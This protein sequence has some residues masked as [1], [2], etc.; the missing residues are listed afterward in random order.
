MAR[1]ATSSPACS[2]RSSTRTG[3]RSGGLRT[4]ESDDPTIAVLDAF[5]VACDVLTFYSE[6]LAN[7]SYLRTATE[8]TSLQEL[9]KL[10]AY[11]LSPGV[12]AE[13]W[14]AFS[15]ERPRR[16]RLRRCRRI[17]A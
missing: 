11:R 1:T 3:Q 14:L 6:R 4:R 12:A 8:R 7:E 2:Q 9:G 5:A 15:L 10:V 13:T 16:R 17:P